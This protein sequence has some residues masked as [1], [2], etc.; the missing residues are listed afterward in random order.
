MTDAA[1]TRL[2][3]RF[4]QTK[5][6]SDSIIERVP[7]AFRRCF[8]QLV[9]KLSLNNLLLKPYSMNKAMP[10]AFSGHKFIGCRCPQRPWANQCTARIYVNTSLQDIGAHSI[11]SEAKNKISQACNL[12]HQE[13]ARAQPSQ[14]WL[15]SFS[16]QPSELEA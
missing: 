10:Q 9:D 12:V 14:A 5:Q 16:K 2:L 1:L 4:I 6:P 7:Q 11:T 13:M 15:L 3:V 8:R